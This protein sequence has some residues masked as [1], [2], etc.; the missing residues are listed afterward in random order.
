VASSEQAAAR[1]GEDRVGKRGAVG[2]RAPGSLPSTVVALS[3]AADVQAPSAARD[4]VVA[5]LGGQV[6]E[7]VLAD[8]RLLVSELVSNSV[9]HAGLAAEDVVR[10]RADLTGGL[11]RLEV[12]DAGTAGSVAARPP[13]VD[14]GF[15]L[16]LV[17]ALAHRWGVTRE[18]FTRVW[19]ELDCRRSRDQRSAW[20][21]T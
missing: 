4:A 10:L 3:V 13:T 12:D 16:H 20:R 9:R 8:A 14:G 17:E 19:I 7:D 2:A 1:C 11:L 5:G 6:A 18:G 21:W 15:G